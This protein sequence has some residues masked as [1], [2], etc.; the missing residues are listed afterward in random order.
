MDLTTPVGR[1]WRGALNVID[2]ELA[3]QPR[4]A[5]HPLARRHLEGRAPMAYLRA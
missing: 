3:G 5:A 2:Q 1:S 4:L